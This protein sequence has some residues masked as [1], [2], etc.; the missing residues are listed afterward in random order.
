MN[1]LYLAIGIFVWCLVM[2]YLFYKL[3]CV[4]C[5]KECKGKTKL[6]LDNPI[7]ETN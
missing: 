3:E 2:G 7:D 4:Q 1:Y 6:C 5:G